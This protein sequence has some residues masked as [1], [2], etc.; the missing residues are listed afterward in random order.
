MCSPRTSSISTTSELPEHP[1]SQAHSRLSQKLWGYIL[2]EPPG[3]SDGQLSWRR[4][5]KL[6]VSAT[7]RYVTWSFLYYYF[8]CKI[9][10]KKHMRN[11]IDLPSPFKDKES[12]SQSH[13]WQVSRKWQLLP[14]CQLLQRLMK[15]MLFEAHTLDQWWCRLSHSCCWKNQPTW[16]APNGLHP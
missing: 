9:S 3:N 1:N 14:S 12:H 16:R 11:T 4:D 13:S 8:I 7:D 2:R 15:E 6:R 5:G 10:Y